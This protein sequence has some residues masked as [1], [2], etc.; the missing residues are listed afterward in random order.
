MRGSAIAWIFFYLSFRQS[1]KIV[2]SL[3]TLHT[4]YA[5]NAVKYWMV[6]VKPNYIFLLLTAA[7]GII[8]EGGGRLQ[9]YPLFSVIK[10][11]GNPKWVHFLYSEHTLLWRKRYC[12]IFYQASYSMFSHKRFAIVN[13]LWKHIRV[14]GRRLY[15]LDLPRTLQ[16]S[17]K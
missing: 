8:G 4:V 14:I 12:C 13:F 6:Q 3:P 10:A 16:P 17:N 7:C 1:L 2:F 9:C 5:L 15:N 11:L